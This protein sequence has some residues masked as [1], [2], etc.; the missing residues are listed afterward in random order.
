M[1][2]STSVLQ[3]QVSPLGQE[4]DFFPRTRDSKLPACSRSGGMAIPPACPRTLC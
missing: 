2:R 1:R 4:F 3:T